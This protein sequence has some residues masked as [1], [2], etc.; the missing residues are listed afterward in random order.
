MEF[1]IPTETVELPS[2]GLLYPEG[3]PLA[4]GT[5]EMKYMTA[6]EED[7]L[8][9]QNYIKKGTVIEKL[10]QSLIVTEVDFNDILIGDIDAIMVAARVLSYGKDYKFT[11]LGQTVEVDLATLDNKELDE[12]LYTRG[13]NE[14]TFKLPNSGNEITFRLLTQGL[15]KAI[16]REIEGLKKINKDN[17]AEVS[18][19]LKY[20]IT[21]INGSRDR[22]DIRKYVDGFMLASDARAL[23]EEYSRVSPGVD[24]SAEV[25]GLDGEQEV[26]DIPIGVTFF[27]PDA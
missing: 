16:A 19:R 12:S 11:Y 21:S 18:T 17:V 27:W 3:H 4:S 20:M 23:R 10:L 5:I 22:A 2:K 14:F 26:V 13:E 1:K 9:N 6:K 25:E 7:I 15:D 24:L 8:S